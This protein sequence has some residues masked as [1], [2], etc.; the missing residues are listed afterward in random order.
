MAESALKSRA[1]QPCGT[2]VSAVFGPVIQVDQLAKSDKSG[3]PSAFARQSL[4]KRLFC[5]ID[6]PF[7]DLCGIL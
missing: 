6:L 4:R 7:W 3:S 2:A 5:R 1:S